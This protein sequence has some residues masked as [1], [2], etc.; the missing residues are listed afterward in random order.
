MNVKLLTVTIDYNY[1]SYDNSC[2]KVQGCLPR[3]QFVD[4]DDNDH[5]H[6][7]QNSWELAFGGSNFK[8]ISLIAFYYS[9]CSGY[10]DDYHHRHRHP[11]GF[12]KISEISDPLGI[13]ATCSHVM[14]IC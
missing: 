12:S 5:D 9:Y 11:H 2:H 6:E 8:F 3:V 1:E 13:T 7:D 14:T 10:D 4:D